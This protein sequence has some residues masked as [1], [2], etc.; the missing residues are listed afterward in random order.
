MGRQMVL[1]RKLCK[2]FGVTDLERFEKQ[3]VSGPDSSAS[4]ETR[5]LSE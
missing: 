2:P 5:R 1:S 3:D 4:H